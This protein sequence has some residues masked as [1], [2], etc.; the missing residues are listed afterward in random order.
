MTSLTDD[1]LADLEAEAHGQLPTRFLRMPDDEFSELLAF[2]NEVLAWSFDRDGDT[3]FDD[4]AA[5]FT[6]PVARIADA[7]TAH[8]WM[9]TPDVH[10]PI[11]SRRIEHDGE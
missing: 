5:H 10:A 11:G 6:V 9:F 4:A 3:T 1:Q 2:A 8:Y 7:V